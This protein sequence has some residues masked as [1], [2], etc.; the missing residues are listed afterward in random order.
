MI[1]P[2]DGI[3]LKPLFEQEIGERR[4]P[5]GF[6]FQDKRALI[7]DRYKL[8]TDNLAAGRFQLYDLQADVRESNDVS[9]EHP[10][11]FNRM[12]QQLLDW[13]SSMNASF[14][15]KDY[16]EGKVAPPDPEPVN[17]YETP[18]Y[19]PYLE[20]WRQRWEFQGFLKR[21]ARSTSPLG[22]K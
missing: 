13:D 5:I 18:S 14:A 3:N 16:A 22:N 4:S 10:E 20:N 17:W 8:L 2:I 9:S 15:G 11:L 6:R 21:A 7:E 1:K 12:K 19:Q